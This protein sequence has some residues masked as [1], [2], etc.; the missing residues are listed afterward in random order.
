MQEPPAAPAT[1]EAAAADAAWRLP[2][3]LA[4][5]VVEAE[6]EQSAGGLAPGEQADRLA[7]RLGPEA[8]VAHVAPYIVALVPAPADRRELRAGGARPAAPRSA[9]RFRGRSRR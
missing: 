2:R 6:G 1:V 4:A 5:L 9:R 8:L 3:T 7:L